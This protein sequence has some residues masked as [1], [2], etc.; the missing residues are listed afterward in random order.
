MSDRELTFLDCTLRD[1]GYYNNWDFSIEVINRYLNAMQAADV[2]VVELG[3]RSVN[4]E[5]FKGA[6]AF[7]TD[8]FIRSL[9][10]PPK[11]K[12]AVMVNAAD[13][14]R[15]DISLTTTLELLFPEPAT[16]SPVSIVRIACHVE[17]FCAALP[18]SLW[19]KD[20]GFK[21]GF[22]LM[23]ISDRQQRE[24]ESLA[25]SAAEWP[26]DVLYFA[27]S[28]GS[29]KPDEVA[30]K[31]SWLRKYW[32]GPLGIHTHDN[33]GL[34]LLNSLR[35]IG[36]GVTWIDSTVTGM[37][38]GPGNAKT[39][40]LALEIAQSR[41]GTPNIVPLMSLVKNVFMPMQHNFG[42]GSNTYYYLAGKYGIHPTYVQ[43]MLSD[44]RYSEED[45]LAVIEHF[46]IVGGRKF[47]IG[48]L[49][50]ARSFYQGPPRGTW[51]PSIVIE[52]RDVLLLGTGPG[53]AIHR[54]ALEEY[55]RKV[56]PF[57]LAL[58]AQSHIS[59]DLIDARVA[60]HPA[61]LLA[62]CE[63]H[64]KLTQPLITPASMLP[65]EVKNTLG[66]KVLYD[67]GL[68][69]KANTFEFSKCHATLPTSLVI[70]YALAVITSGNARSIALAGFDGYA[71]DDPRNKEM[72]N[73]F[74][75]YSLQSSAIKLTAI[76]PTRYDIA[77]KS[78]YGLI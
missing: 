9:S 42:W 43:E 63:I 10:V 75:L 17:E 54:Q 76:T 16:S 71:A 51:Q 53:V 59:D 40:Y 44:S 11:L 28:M 66:D 25:Q 31:V 55:I 2:D 67:Y 77:A 73:L 20:R 41:D 64:K 65:A 45:I 21:V 52:G 74:R 61:R 35:A 22:N 29:M 23:Q 32:G 7:T 33:M 60:C 8:G 13:L 4:N 57:V 1:G 38:R 78:I 47:S 24:I 36:E 49:D 26:L 37:G 18:A 50:S 56:K 5:S 12:I 72:S 19:L 34:A 62:D 58:N 39:E 68:E 27:D 6:C 15:G 48:K 46:R 14:F 3:L 30:E 69:V 70:A